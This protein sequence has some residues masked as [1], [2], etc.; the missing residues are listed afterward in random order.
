MFYFMLLFHIFRC[1]FLF[2]ISI[3]YFPLITFLFRVLLY[4]FVYSCSCPQVMF[5]CLPYIQSCINPVIYVL[6]SKK[7]RESVC[8]VPCVSAVASLCTRRDVKHSP[9]HELIATNHSAV[10]TGM[11]TSLET[12]RSYGASEFTDV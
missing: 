8:S 9:T 7:I 10:V 12:V 4:F 3:T 6:M 2:H 11:K 1:L 5:S